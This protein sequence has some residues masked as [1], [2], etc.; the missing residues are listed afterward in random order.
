MKSAG[1]IVLGLV[2]GWALSRLRLVPGDPWLE[3]PAV[4]AQSAL[5]ARAAALA[6]V[7]TALAGFR[8][9]VPLSFLF[10]LLAGSA[11]HGLGLG[12]PLGMPLWDIL[13]LGLPLGLARGPARRAAGPEQEDEREAH[14]GER[15]GLALA[16]A[17]TAVALEVVARHVR[18]LGGGLVQDDSAFAATF[19]LLVALGAACFGWAASVRAIQRLS[20]PMLLAAAAAAAYAGL[21]V[22]EEIGSILG[23]TRFLGRWGLDASWHA[24]LAA[25]ALVAGAAFV[26]PAFLLGAAVRG[27]RG[28]GS[29]SSALYGAAGGLALLPLLLRREAQ[30]PTGAAELF[31][32]QFVP[33]GVMAA[34][35]GAALA[36]LSVKQRSAR[37]RWTAVAACAPLALPVLL[38]PTKPLFLLSPWEKRPTMPFVAFET[39]EGLATVEPGDGSLKIATLERRALSPDLLGLGSDREQLRAAFATLHESERTGGALRVL[40]VGQLTLPRAIWLAELG[41]AR[42]DR[43]GAWHAAMPALE[44]A[45]FGD[46]ALPAGDVIDPG[47]AAERLERGDY[48]LAIAPA[49]GGDPPAWS[50]IEAP[51]DTVVVR[52]SS[53]EERPLRR[54]PPP[55][56]P[57]ESATGS[58]PERTYLLA[59]SGLVRPALGVTWASSLRAT[60]DADRA[61]LVRLESGLARP[62]PLARL[63][64]RKLFR[65]D[66]ARRAAIEALASEDP[67]PLLEGYAAWCRIQ[68]PSSP[69]ETAAERV[70][71]DPECLGL[72]REA[73]LAGPPSLFVRSA[74]EWLARVLA[75][76]RDVE[77]IYAQLEP[78]ARRHAPWPALEIA[79]ARADLESLEPAAAIARLETLAAR[80]LGGA[81]LQS[82]LAEALEQDG[83]EARAL[84]A[85]REAARLRPG[86]RGIERRLAM[87]LV[88]A[89][90]PEGP[91]L[92]ERLLEAEPGDEELAAFRGPGPWPAPRRGFQPGPGSR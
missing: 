78:I 33:F 41:A 18:L 81:E 23:F 17:G 62:T 20:F 84:A 67:R 42:V 39:P 70:E 13:L 26:L 79:L 55:Q 64:E 73:A 6:V 9:G 14:W 50:T 76:K 15:V 48:D 86:D 19:A 38:V 28:A 68:V 74:W 61:E 91:P 89:G 85:W 36:V 29:L 30:A 87:A 4:S 88:R 8:R 65:P 27:A 11:V 92:V 25:D 60:P 80:G 24:T 16:G 59:G 12:A 77:A 5:F 2:S 3:G 51:A 21:A 44:A 57:F 56:D 22:V 75:G 1:A 83:Q 82:A 54:L 47:E 31:A 90:D 63:L 66:A 7:G 72:L 35:M 32:A 53:L 69:F 46:Q 58:S 40:L 43:T 34:V 49:A 37:A 10:A 52:W 71:L 45:L